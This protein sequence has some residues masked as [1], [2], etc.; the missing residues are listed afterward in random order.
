M[1]VRNHQRLT[2]VVDTLIFTPDDHKNIEK[3][4]WRKKLKPVHFRQNV[5]NRHI[6]LPP[7][8]EKALKTS[9]TRP[10]AS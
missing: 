7:F 5:L 1:T 3:K 6:F 10:N 4:H 9:D 8:C 2:P